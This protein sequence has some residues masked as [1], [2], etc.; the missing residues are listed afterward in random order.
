MKIKL[1]AREPGR[2]ASGVPKNDTSAERRRR[3][4][5]LAK[6]RWR[7]ALPAERE[8]ARRKALAA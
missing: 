4:E 6:I 5:R 7:K 1:S 3:Q 2:R 8:A